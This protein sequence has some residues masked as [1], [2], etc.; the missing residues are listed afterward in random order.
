MTARDAAAASPPRHAQAAAIARGR[1]LFNRADFWASHEAWEAAWRTAAEPERSGLQGLIQA[2]AALHKFVVQNNPS[3]AVRLID[4]AL[5]GM[6]A[7]GPTGLGLD[8]AALSSEL[9]EWRRRLS[10]G[11][12][13]D[14][15][16][17]GLPHL[18]RAAVPPGGLQPAPL[19]VEAIDVRIVEDGRRRALL[20]AVAAD[21]H[22]GW[23]ESVV[24]WS[25][26]GVFDAMCSSLAPALLT[27]SVGSPAELSVVW[28]G[29]AAE[30]RA[31]AALEM[32]VWD[33]FARRL[34]VPLHVALGAAA[35]PVAV[36]QRIHGV[37]AA[38]LADGIGRARA[39]GFTAVHLP[40]RPNADQRLLPALVPELHDLTFAFDLDGAYRLA[41]VHALAALDRLAP[42]FLHRPFPDWA[43][44]DIVR[45]RRWLGS[46]ISI[47]N[48]VGAEALANAFELGAAAIAHVDPTAIG[49]SEAGLVLETARGHGVDAWVG[50]PSVTPVAARAALALAMAPGATLPCAPGDG[51]GRWG[52]EH[53]VDGR[54]S[55]PDGAGMAVDPP[56][57]WLAVH[58][59]RHERLQA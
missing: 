47:G 49:L 9:R 12:P 25:E 29:V 43:V 42:S 20:V 44:A 24:P 45:L 21:G 34:G 10:D 6:S 52:A 23:G 2:A 14:A 3:G 55:A 46:P 40:A 11:P 1:A 51:F 17:I 32:A 57:E 22:V 37:T 5:E 54:W 13:S 27:E 35:R 48:V 58:E 15:S 38:A 39:A 26:H 53:I 28:R 41:D 56:P 7:V 16:I 50:T 18:E 59:V 33:L 30:G 36:A 8:L 19:S 4:R 31:A